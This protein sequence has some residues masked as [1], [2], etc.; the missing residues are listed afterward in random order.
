MKL[1]ISTFSVILV[2]GLSLLMFILWSLSLVFLVDQQNQ[3]SAQIMQQNLHAQVL[4]L[5]QKQRLW[6]QSQ[7][8][9]LNT[10]AKSPADKQNFQSFLWDYYQHNPSIWAVNAP[11]ASQLLSS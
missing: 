11:A 6:L 2:A 7:Y 5:Q 3:Q 10:L 9:L 4:Q 1:N 8:Y